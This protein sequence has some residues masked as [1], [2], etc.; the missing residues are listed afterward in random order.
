MK[1][2]I[3]PPVRPRGFPRL[4]T[5]SAIVDLLL[6]RGY[7]GELEK[8]DY[9]DV[10][11]ALGWAPEETWFRLIR[12]KPTR[13]TNFVLPAKKFKRWPIILGFGDGPGNESSG[14]SL[15]DGLHRCAVTRTS[16]VMLRARLA[17]GCSTPSPGHVS[18][19]KKWAGGW[20]RPVDFRRYLPSMKAITKE[21]VA[22]LA[23]FVQGNSFGYH[24][25]N[26]SVFLHNTARLAERIAQDL[27]LAPGSYDIRTNRGGIAVSG[28]VHLQSN[29]L[30]VSFTA[31]SEFCGAKRFMFR[32]CRSR[33]DY[34]G[35]Q[36]RWVDW[37]DLATAG[38]YNAALEDM[39]RTMAEVVETPVMIVKT[40]A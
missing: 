21:Q 15:V 12:V 10:R 9:G 4:L 11:H 34:V 30:Y 40:A 23:R 2:R 31:D 19:G 26:K 5:K 3:Y 33:K 22:V 13:F 8:M 16:G 36:N 1:L 17:G 35:L 6:D 32:R 38:G 28:D 24:P 18:S 37:M 25:Q 14:L 20:R 27:E 29:S 39:R 7:C